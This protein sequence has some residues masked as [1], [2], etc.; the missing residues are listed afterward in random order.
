MTNFVQITP[1]P[2]TNQVITQS[3]NDPEFGYVRVE[4]KTT[5]FENGWVRIATRS[6]LI[7]GKVEDLKVFEGLKQIPGKILVKESLEP[8]YDG[9]APKINPQTGEVLTNAGRPIYRQTFF[10]QNMNDTD[11]FI[12]HDTVAVPK[13][14]GA[15]G[16]DS[17]DNGI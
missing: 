14:V 5:T 1:N 8:A 12:S 16:A 15:N 11:L 9:Q 6:A 10:T 13:T 4:S 3:S 2:E 17:A 7:R